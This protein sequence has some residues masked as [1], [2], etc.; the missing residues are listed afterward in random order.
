MIIKGDNMAINQIQGSLNDARQRF[1]PKGLRI[2]EEVNEVRKIGS[3]LLAS[4]K[5]QKVI[6]RQIK[7]KY[8][9]A[10]GKVFA[11]LRKREEAEANEVVKRLE[12]AIKDYSTLIDHLFGDLYVLIRLISHMKQEAIEDKKDPVM[13]Q[14]FR[15]SSRMLGTTLKQ[16]MTRLANMAQG[17]ATEADR[18]LRT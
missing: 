2:W 16:P 15:R 10:S 14:R 5:D 6:D 7:E 4:A 17:I 12:S 11:Q 18:L 1:V 13:A 8:Q 3:N 9:A